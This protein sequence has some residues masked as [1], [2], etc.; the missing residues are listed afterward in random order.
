MSTD[1]RDTL[2]TAESG[3][4]KPT[5]PDLMPGRVRWYAIISLIILA[6]SLAEF[7]TGSSQILQAIINRAGFVPNIGLY[8]GG[9]LLIREAAVRWK[10]RWGAI[11]LLGGAY[12]VGE[13]G[14]AA[15]TMINPTS[16]IIGN[17]LYTHWLGVNWVP[18]A[19]L[20][21][22]H[23]AFSIAVPLLLVEL[24]FPDTKGRKLLGNFGITITMAVYGL[25]V[26][27][28]TLYLGDPYMLSLGITIF[29]AVYAS[30]FI[31]AAYFVP[32]SFL[33]ARGERP[34]RRE[35]NFVLLGLG[36]MVGFFVIPGNLSPGGG[37]VSHVLTWPVT[38]ALLVPLAGLTAWYLVRHAGRSENDLVKIDFVLGMMLIFVP[39][40]IVRELGGDAGALPFTALILAIMIWLRQQ[41]KHP[42]H[43]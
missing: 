38:A 16:P 4:L 43:Q 17:Q 6:A 11:L 27:V 34:D 39:L 25:T 8:G 36:F 20:T 33:H 14:F 26:S 24:L 28:L 10:K 7:L 15:K 23:A 9:A 32:G 1:T 12:S 30:A 29:L 41:R 3:P 22:F 42:T 19:A 40:S 2:S 21:L 37:L 13:E 31:I 5:R 35:R 18:L